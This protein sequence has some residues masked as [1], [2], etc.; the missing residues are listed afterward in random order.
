MSI[1]VLARA[2]NAAVGTT[3]VGGTMGSGVYSA[4]SLCHVSTGTVGSVTGGT[5]PGGA[6][7]LTPAGLAGKGGAVEAVECGGTGTGYEGCATDQG[8]VV[9]WVALGIGK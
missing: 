4:S 8:D 3:S 6:I 9:D 1:G 2:D 7:V 5:A